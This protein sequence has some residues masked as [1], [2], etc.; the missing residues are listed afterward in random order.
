M[1]LFEIEL[2]DGKKFQVETDR[3]PTEAEL[4]QLMEQLQSGGIQEMNPTGPARGREDWMQDVK[5]GEGATQLP[6]YQGA[7][8]AAETAGAAG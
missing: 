7:I 4:P 1:P 6:W 5:P 3:E 8:S 2:V